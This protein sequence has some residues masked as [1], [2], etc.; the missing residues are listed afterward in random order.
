[1]VSQDRRDFAGFAGIPAARA[2]WQPPLASPSLPRI[3]GAEPPARPHDRHGHSSTGE[4]P[5]NR[6]PRDDSGWICPWRPA[7]P[8]GPACG[9]F[10]RWALLK[11]AIDHQFVVS[12]EPQLL[13]LRSEHR[14]GRHQTP[15]AAITLLNPAPL[16]RRSRLA[17]SLPSRVIC[18][19]SFRETRTLVNGRL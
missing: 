3:A 5:F 16:D 8:L 2:R 4:F 7:V 14:Q 1:M 13:S 9:P 15:R 6:R 18:S 10:A 17:R 19:A 12:T 11:L